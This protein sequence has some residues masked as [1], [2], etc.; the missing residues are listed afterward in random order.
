MT[1]AE[2]IRTC[3]VHLRMLVMRVP[4]SDS[5]VS[6]RPLVLLHPSS[7]PFSEKVGSHLQDAMLTCCLAAWKWLSPLQ[8]LFPCVQRQE[9]KDRAGQGVYF[10]REKRNL[11]GL[12]SSNRLPFTSPR[13]E[14]TTPPTPREKKEVS[15]WEYFLSLCIDRQA[16]EKGWDACGSAPE[17]STMA[18]RTVL[19][20]ILCPAWMNQPFVITGPIKSSVR[21][22]DESFPCQTWKGDRKCNRSQ[23]FLQSYNPLHLYNDFIPAVSNHLH[24]HASSFKILASLYIWEIGRLKLWSQ[25]PAVVDWEPQ[26]LDLSFFTVQLMLSVNLILK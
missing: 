23:A 22:W 25:S 24:S 5:T 18:L 20:F 17:G 1:G 10:F 15:R 14:P 6:P 13:P 11:Q 9:M 2:T 3:V 12:S 21:R 7:L 8:A 19:S 4:R 26:F 16:G